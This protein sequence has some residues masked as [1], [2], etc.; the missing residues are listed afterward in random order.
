MTAMAALA[1]GVA[2]ASA[3]IQAY[4]MPARSRRRKP[5]APHMIMLRHDARYWPLTAHFPAF[6][7]AYRASASVSA[8]PA[9]L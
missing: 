4:C 8:L 7:L 9:L 3:G 6:S 1:R 5:Y 2:M